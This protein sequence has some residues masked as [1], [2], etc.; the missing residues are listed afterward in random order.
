[1]FSFLGSSI[2]ILEGKLDNEDGIVNKENVKY[3]GKYKNIYCIKLL[4]YV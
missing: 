4:L 2:I 1:M 3:M